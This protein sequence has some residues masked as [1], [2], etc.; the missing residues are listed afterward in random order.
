[1]LMEIL[2][3]LLRASVKKGEKVSL[4]FDILIKKC[5]SKIIAETEYISFNLNL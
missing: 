4:T 3:Q 2:K 5:I 1:M